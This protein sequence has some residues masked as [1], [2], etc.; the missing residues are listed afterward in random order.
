MIAIYCRQSVE[1]KDSISI[2][3][4]ETAC[5]RLTGEENCIV[6][7]DKG[8]TGANTRRPGFERMMRNINMGMIHKVIVYKVDRIS[9]SLL[10]FVEIYGIFERHQV[11]FVS[12]S[13]QFDTSTAMGKAT[14]QIIMVFAELERNMIQK[15]VKDNFYERA[16]KGL[17]LSG[18]APYGFCKKAVT[19]DGIHTHQ[20][21]PDQDHPETLQAVKRM[22]EEYR[23]HQSLS[24][25]ARALNEQGLRTNRGNPFS[26]AAV[27]RILRNPVY[28]RADADVYHYLRVRGAVLNQSVEEYTG[29]FGCTVYGARK[30]K[31]T[32]KFS[33]LHGEFVQLNRHEG[34]ISSAEWLAVQYELDQNKPVTNSG[35][36]QNTWLTGLTKCQFCGMGVT[37]VNGQRNGKRY[38][39]CGGKKQHLCPGRTVVM[40]FDELES[41]A[42]DSLL[43]TIRHFDFS[44][45]RQEQNRN[46][47]VN[48]LKIRLTKC[49]EEIGKL[50]HK[51]ADANEALMK[52]LN[53]RIAS[54][55]TEIRQTESELLRLQGQTAEASD[56]ESL[57]RILTDENLLGFEEKKL[58]A[59]TFWQKII[60]GDG[61]IGIV[62]R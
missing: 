40:T 49:R 10:D 36:G 57:N 45:I 12:C 26:S 47:E 58:L 46:M 35:K 44:E 21:A 3:Q 29:M 28:V 31:T 2:E 19:I 43:R 53:A 60:V 25:I 30:N 8:F 50:L 59:G 15:R 22:Y 13:E 6:F 4:Q 51:V 62:Y 18:V 5:R 48:R 42:L 1:K 54:L 7:A 55:D 11:E 14:L 37:V 20:L 38:L 17:Y 34:I 16:R 9:R 23:L 56:T 61:E 39:N 32:R 27:S 41:A 52:Y 33:D 24:S